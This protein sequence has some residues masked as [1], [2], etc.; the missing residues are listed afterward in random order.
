[1]RADDPLPVL[2]VGTSP[3]TVPVYSLKYV[4]CWLLLLLVA[5]HAKDL[6]ENIAGCILVVGLS[7]MS[8]ECTCRYNRSDVQRAN[9][10]SRWQ[11]SCMTSARVLPNP[12]HG[13]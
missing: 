10:G 5:L 11:A 9:N 13:K 4:V 7:F 1:M 6:Q 8:S 12:V 3:S 2:R